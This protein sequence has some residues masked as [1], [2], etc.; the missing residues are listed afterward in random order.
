VDLRKIKKLIELADEAGLAELEVRSGDEAVRITRGAAA[1]PSP[2]AA[3]AAECA[4]RSQPPPGPETGGGE[5]RAPMAGTFYRASAPGAEPFLRVGQAVAAGDVVCII[6]S[7]KMMNEI[8][9][10]ADGICA[11]VDRDDGAPVSTGDLL[12]RLR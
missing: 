2:P 3:T 12:F 8:T 7:M 1:G 5:L 6:E 4:K 11:S 10:E 9:A